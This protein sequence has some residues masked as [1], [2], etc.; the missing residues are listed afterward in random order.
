MAVK[1]GI[2]EG[3]GEQDGVSIAQYAAWNEYGVTGKQGG[4]KLWKI[5]PRPFIRKF[6]ENKDSEIKAAQEKM[7]KLVAA[8]KMD[9]ETA[10]RR[11]GQFAQDGIKNYIETG[12]FTKNS[13][14]TINGS[15]PGKDGK[16]F[17][18]G[19]K[20]SKPLIDTGTMR[21]SVRYEVVKK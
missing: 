20:S 3:S 6:V 18:K 11:L 8:G 5:P 4:K 13:D 12:T 19:K 17:I 14:V 2:V 21:N 7:V 10:I 15:K 9:A 1:A 16:K